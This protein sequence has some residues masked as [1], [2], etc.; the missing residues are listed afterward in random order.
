MQES[1]NAGKE[2]RQMTI[3][4][5]TF[6]ITDLKVNRAP[7]QVSMNNPIKFDLVQDLSSYGSNT[8]NQ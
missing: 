8:N 1:S 4:T 6:I 2:I 3:V 7:L 5:V